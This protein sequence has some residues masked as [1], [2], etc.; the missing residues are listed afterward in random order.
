M[1]VR[2]R[3]E[4]CHGEAGKR[5]DWHDARATAEVE[6]AAG[7]GGGMHQQPCSA[8][9]SASSIQYHLH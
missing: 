1:S 2:W 6:G 8:R 7:G 5:W 9:S 3:Q 4:I